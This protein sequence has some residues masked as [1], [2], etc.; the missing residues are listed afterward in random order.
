MDVCM[1]VYVEGEGGTGL[2]KHSRGEKRAAGLGGEGS[3][4]KTFVSVRCTSDRKELWLTYRIYNTGT[5]QSVSTDL[6]DTP[7]RRINIG[8]AALFA[9][10]TRT[11]RRCHSTST[12]I[13]GLSALKNSSVIRRRSVDV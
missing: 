9:T 10:T 12:G 13:S 3:F 1:R 5:I 11:S 2:S 4:L 6:M 7:E 8:A